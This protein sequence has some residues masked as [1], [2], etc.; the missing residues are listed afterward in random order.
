MLE[1]LFP[2]PDF[3]ELFEF[4]LL[5]KVVLGLRVD[6][7]IESVMR[8]DPSQIDKPD[9]S[10]TTP[11]AWAVSRGDIKATEKLLS[12]QPDCNKLDRWGA[13]PLGYA[14]Q[15]SAKCTELLLDANANVHIKYIANFTVLHWAAMS[16]PHNHE[17]PRIVEVLLRAGVDINAV[18]SRNETVL[19]RTCGVEAVECLIRNGI[20]M[21]ICTT[22]GDSALSRATRENNHD[23]IR[24][25]LQGKQDHT[26]HLTRYGTFLHMVAQFANTETLKLLTHANLQRRPINLTNDAGLT[27]VEVSHQRRNVGDEWQ[28]TFFDFLESVRENPMLEALSSSDVALT[29]GMPGGWPSTNNDD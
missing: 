6:C 20:D 28:S 1:T 27:P 11:L 3:D 14:A 4:S 2:D 9:S 10:G 18:T 29:A 22:D 16:L 19:Y 24:L 7:S 13:S 15:R 12:Y 17:F 5:H 25:F 21:S 26:R 23:L 8:I